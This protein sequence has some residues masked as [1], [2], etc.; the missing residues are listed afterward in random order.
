MIPSDNI[1]DVLLAMVAKHSNRSTRPSSHPGDIRSVLSQPTKAAKAKVQDH[2]ISVK[3]HTYVQQVLSHDIQ[4]SVSQAS[5][6]KKS[7]LID[8]GANGGIAGI[9]TRVIERHP[10]RTVNIRGIDNHEITSI[11][12]V[13]AG[14]VARSQRGDAILIMHQPSKSPSQFANS[15]C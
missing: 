15:V 9:D 10:H 6:R 7:S 11:P 3:S 4:Y 1:D 5:R 13:T 12:I 2:E 14:A 8:Q